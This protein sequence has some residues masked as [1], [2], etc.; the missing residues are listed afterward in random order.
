MLY[1]VNNK[2][3][4]II[5]VDVF[6]ESLTYTGNLPPGKPLSITVY[7]KDNVKSIHGE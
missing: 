4:L 6:S 5:S 3:P 1:A 7:D 2:D